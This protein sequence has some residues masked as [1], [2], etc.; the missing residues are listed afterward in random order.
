MPSAVCLCSPR[1]DSIGIW[2]KC[3]LSPRMFCAEGTA[4]E[5]GSHPVTAS[6]TS[7]PQPSASYLDNLPSTVPAGAAER[8]DPGPPHITS[9]KTN[10][11]NTIAGA[12]QEA[13][14]PVHMTHSSKQK[15]LAEGKHTSDALHPPPGCAPWRDKADR[16]RGSS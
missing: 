12:T 8:G 7:A 2:Q 15:K 9:S 16:E 10:L 14:Q 1:G 4:A 13:S 6:H 5:S 11:R 3:N